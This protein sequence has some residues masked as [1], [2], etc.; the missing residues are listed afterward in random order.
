MNE[1]D[2][3]DWIKLVRAKLHEKHPYAWNDL[4]E[5]QQKNILDLLLAVKIKAVRHGFGADSAV[6][7]LE[8]LAGWT[9]KQKLLEVTT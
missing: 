5:L 7:L 8:C 2:Q 3:R 9:M 4:D 1:A 6:E